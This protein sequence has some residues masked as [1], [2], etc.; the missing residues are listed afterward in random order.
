MLKKLVLLLA[1]LGLFGAAADTASAHGY[2]RGSYCYR[3]YY[4]G[5]GGG[6]IQP[7]YGAYGSYAGNGFYGFRSPSTVFG[8]SYG[9]GYAPYGGYGYGRSFSA[10]FGF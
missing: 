5:Y 7:F 8:P 10:S 3:P 4:G 2:G 9:Y 6:Y 1:L